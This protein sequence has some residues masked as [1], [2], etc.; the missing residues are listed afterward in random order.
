MFDQEKVNLEDR[1][2]M[3]SELKLH[4]DDLVLSYIGEIGT[5]YHLDEMLAFLPPTLKFSTQN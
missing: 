2:K 3:Q 5:W 4:P 1:Q